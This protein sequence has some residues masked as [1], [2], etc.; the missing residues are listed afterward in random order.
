MAT[1]LDKSTYPQSHTANDFQAFGPVCS[2]DGEF[3]GTMMA[4]LGC[5]AQGDVDSN[6]FYF[7]C[8]VQSKKNQQWYIFY[9]WGRTGN[10]NNQWQMVE[11]YD[12]ADAQRA[13][14]DQM[15]DKND[16]RGMWTQHPKLGRILEAKPGK[17][18]YLVRQLATR[19][20]GL[21]DAQT[22]TQ[23]AG[24]KPVVPAISSTATTKKIAAPKTDAETLKLLRDLQVG[25]VAYTRSSMSGNTIPSQSAIDEARTILDESIKSVKRVGDDIKAQVVDKELMQLTSMLYSRIPKNKARGASPEDWILSKNNILGW[26]QDLDS[27]ESALYVST[28][29]SHTNTDPYMGMPF[30]LTHLPKNTELGSYFYD[31]MPKSTRDMHHGIGKLKIINLWAIDREGESTKM[32]MAQEKITRTKKDIPL[33][34]PSN[35]IDLSKEEENAYK[36]SGTWML[37]HGTR[38][39]SVIGISQSGFRFP[40]QLAGS[41]VAITGAMFG[42]GIYLADDYKKSILYS[43]HRAAS[44][45]S[46]SGGI[47]GRGSFLFLVD[48]VL[49]NAYVAPNSYSY[50]APPKD[51]HSIFG[52]AGVS[53]VL[54][55]EF[56]LFDT[57]QQR[58]RYLVEFDA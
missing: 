23:N 20:Y 15:H 4:D 51:Y 3:S 50:A 16:K 45:S 47:G 54:N 58:L 56:I 37:W 21:P 13:Y 36:T 18:V 55:N 11:C 41:G 12:K 22:I 27:F 32:Q 17:D 7:G 31:W 38:S 1:K 14:E 40:K 8:V 6:K 10:T 2:K 42:S 5:F 30:Q 53:G 19:T 48:S 35:R 24:A 49:G 9:E 26:R 34:Q 29:T 43:S 28:N 33:H 52:K 46:G 39:S 44:Y 57:A 25:T